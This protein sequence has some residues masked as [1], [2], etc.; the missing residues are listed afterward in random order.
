MALEPFSVILRRARRRIL[1]A[2]FPF[3]P[4]TNWKAVEP[5]GFGT[6]PNQAGP[7]AVELRARANRLR[8]YARLYGE[9]EIASRL[10]ALADDL[11]V[12]AAGLEQIA[13]EN[14]DRLAP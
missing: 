13:A 6:M 7:D 10:S 8:Y 12:R 2:I 11:E 14:S 3:R 9:G 5:H 1:P 4:V